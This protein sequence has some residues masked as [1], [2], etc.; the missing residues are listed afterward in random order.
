VRKW[1]KFGVATLTLAMVAGCSS[2]TNSNTQSLTAADKAALTAALSSTEF[3]GLAA[4]V[5]QTVGAVGTL[6]AA[7]N[8]AMSKAVDGALSLAVQGT[9]SAAYEGAVGIAI[10]YNYN[11]SGQSEQGWFYGVFG[12]NDINA[13]AKTVGEW[14]LVG[15]VGST[16]SLPSSASGTVESGDVFAYYSQSQVPY[17]G[18][19]GTASVTGS[20]FSGN[21]DCGASSGGVTVVCSYGTGSMNGNLEFT[22]VSGTDVSYAQPKVQFSN[23]PAVKM[24]ISV[25]Q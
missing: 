23:L 4:Y 16:G 14:L 11:V 1:T 18:T 22:A 3:G 20:S 25:S 2:S 12:W 8:A 10:E 19:T 5:V 17:T 13:T 9:N 15:G 24:T 7:T 21:T 6:T